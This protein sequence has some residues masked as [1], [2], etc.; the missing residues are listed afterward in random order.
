LVRRS[1]RA[2]W[3][4]RLTVPSPFVSAPAP[5]CSRGNQNATAEAPNPA[6]RCVSAASIR[7]TPWARH[8]EVLGPEHVSLQGA[9]SAGCRGRSS[10]RRR[11]RV[12][13]PERVGVRSSRLTG[14]EVQSSRRD[15]YATGRPRQC[16][17]SGLPA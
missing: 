6:E 10:R 14:A 1:P 12:R 4:S 3:T 8:V 11:F 9:S 17:L 13:A 15:G 16:Q 7:Y 5:L 2:A